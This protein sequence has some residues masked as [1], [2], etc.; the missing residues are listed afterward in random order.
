MPLE[1][2]EEGET[3][4]RGLEGLE[5]NCRCAAV[6]SWQL[7]V[8]CCDSWRCMCVRRDGGETSAQ[9]LEG[10]EANCRCSAVGS[11]RL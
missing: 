3:S 10:L 8:G 6:G 11:W 4:T 9:G 1:G 5:A 2:G 7:A